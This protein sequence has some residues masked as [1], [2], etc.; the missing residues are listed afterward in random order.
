MPERGYAI[1]KSSPRKNPG[2]IGEQWENIVCLRADRKSKTDPPH[3]DKRGLP[4]R[5]K[6][7][8]CLLCSEGTVGDEPKRGFA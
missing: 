4:T 7:G 8:F 5:G 3:G 2:S 1:R 6:N